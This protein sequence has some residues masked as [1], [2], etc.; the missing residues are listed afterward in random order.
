LTSTPDDV[1]VWLIRA[2][3]PATDAGGLAAVLDED[4]RRRAARHVIDQHR[5]RFIAAHGVARVIIGHRL[6]VP[7]ERIGWRRGPHGKP[8][9]TGTPDLHVN[10]SHS[11]DL[12]MLA[13]TDG[14]RCGIDVQL[15]PD[16]TQAVRLARRFFPAEET[17]FVA[18]AAEPAD[19]V[20][21]FGL[22]WTRKEACVKATGAR[23]V[24]GLRLPVRGGVVRD[25]GGPLPGPYRVRDLT[26]PARF[27]AAVALEGDRPFRVLRHW[28]PAEL[29]HD[30]PETTDLAVER[31]STVTRG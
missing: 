22:L 31:C 16:P 12:A 4:E 30:I 11:G 23:L 2:V 14:R 29:D 1:H 3:I 24:P 13:M 6:G 28:W 8:E 21:R 19:R 18:S 25:P 10:M 27:M 5:R 26:A 9:L 17:R 15:L 20:H 7:A